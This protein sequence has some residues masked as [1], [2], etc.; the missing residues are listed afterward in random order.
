MTSAT[1]WQF[2]LNQEPMSEFWTWRRMRFDGTIEQM[3]DPHPD[4]G[5]IIVNAVRNGFLPKEDSWVVIAGDRHTHFAPGQPPVTIPPDSMPIP[6]AD[7]MALLR[8]KTELRD[9]ARG[10]PADSLSADHGTADGSAHQD[11]SQDKPERSA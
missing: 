7:H 9:A 3:S 6:F 8:R 4:F 1:H 2:V 10:G 11:F 5:G